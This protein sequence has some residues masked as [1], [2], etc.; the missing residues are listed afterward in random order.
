MIDAEGFMSKL[1]DTTYR[2]T[3]PWD[4]AGSITGSNQA[5]RR[6]SRR[7]VATT[8]LDISSRLGLTKINDRGPEQAEKS[9]TDFHPT[10][11]VIPDGLLFGRSSPPFD[12]QIIETSTNSLQRRVRLELH[13]LAD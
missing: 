7:P 6:A 2:M 11:A 5:Q 10:E 3:A 12:A 1:L 9:K 4:C 13:Q 8:A